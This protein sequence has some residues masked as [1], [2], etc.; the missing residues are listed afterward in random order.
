VLL[1]ALWLGGIGISSAS[2][3]LVAERPFSP[4]GLVIYLLAA[5]P[6]APG[7]VYL[8]VASGLFK[9]TD[10]GRTWSW[11]GRGLGRQ[12]A[13]ALAFDPSR[14]GTLYL[15]SSDDSADLFGSTDGG[16]SWQRLGAPERNENNSIGR[17]LAIDGS[18]TIYAA[19]GH[20]LFATSDRGK[21]WVPLRDFQAPI[22]SLAVSPVSPGTLYVTNSSV[23]GGVSIP[24]Q[25]H[26][27]EDGGRTWREIGG[28]AIPPEFGPR[29]GFG[30]VFL[31]VAATRPETL[32][33]GVVGRGVYRST[34]RGGSWRRLALA[35]PGEYLHLSALAVDRAD[36]ATVYAAIDGTV[37]ASSRA[38]G[39]VAVSHD[40]GETWRN[41]DGLSIY[42]GAAGHLVVDSTGALF[43]ASTSGALE[44]STEKQPWR[45]LIRRQDG[46]SFPW[47]GEVRFRPGAPS[48]VCTL[49]AG[50]LWKSADGGQSWTA[51][52][53]A[54]GS[55]FLND[56][57]FDAADP[58]LLYAAAETGVFR[59]GDGGES[60][61]RLHQTA[62]KALVLP[63]PGT[64]VA[65]GCGIARSTDGGKT[66][67]EVLPCEKASAY[68]GR[69]V[70]KL[71]I[72]PAAPDEILATFLGSFVRGVR[73]RSVYRSR[74][75]GATW[76]LVAGASLVA[77][78][79]RDPR[80]LYAAKGTDLA[81]STDGGETWTTV[82]PFGETGEPSDLVVDPARP[83]ILYGVTTWGVA[84]S[85]DAGRTWESEP[86][87]FFVVNA[88]VFLPHPTVRDL[89]YVGGSNAIYEV[90]LEP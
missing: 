49:L 11:S 45:S 46:G 19:I 80:T 13:G 44:V 9:S 72:H 23:G 70:E 64:L 6:S 59:S 66:W 75:G 2:A 29:V 34:D 73:S 53:A 1:A 85:R 62:A 24:G 68:Q 16:A 61:T 35:P 82:G 56:V 50:Q 58:N 67:K 37:S 38:P 8:S 10:G 83:E 77:H 22:Q 41:R 21:T 88:S 79:S 20:V 69:E 12:G 18:G 48:T 87:R 4:A 7:T 89:F 3:E 65:G 55:P 40:Q 26:A 28:E 25:L 27:S 52:A 42:F 57:A 54:P 63:R 32:Y 14:P 36:P 74:D 71:R 31:A 15:L 17:E 33:A 30:T 78:D 47:K 60:W 51:Y 5:D 43:A 86:F 90:R 39:R 81:K 76:E 84:R